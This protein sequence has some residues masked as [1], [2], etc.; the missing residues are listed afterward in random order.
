MPDLEAP[1]AGLFDWQSESVLLQSL[2]SDTFSLLLERKHLIRS[3]LPTSSVDDTIRKNIHLFKTGVEKLE[4]E[5]SKAESS[6]KVKDADLKEWEQSVL[7]LGRTA[8]RL[9][10]NTHVD[11]SGPSQQHK[12]RKEL[13]SATPGSK[14]VRFEH[15]PSSSS[16]DTQDDVDAHGHLRLQQRLMDQQ[17]DHLDALSETLS[18]QKQIGLMIGDELDLHVDLLDETEERVDG[19]RARLSRAGRRLEDVVRREGGSS[20]GNT[21]ICILVLIL[22]LVIVL[23]RKF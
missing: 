21:I 4:E 18:R 13:L 11:G 15:P 16:E 17:D 6:G 22:I 12:E 9:E 1:S 14:R 10:E 8:T 19:V 5:L 20:K 23:A 2:A 7:E 3:S